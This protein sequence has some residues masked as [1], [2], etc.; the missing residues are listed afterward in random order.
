M[1][2]KKLLIEHEI[3]KPS[4]V[5]FIEVVV[6][7][8]TSEKGARDCFI[9]E[10]WTGFGKTRAV[11]IAALLATYFIKAEGQ[12]KRIIISCNTKDQQHH[13]FEELKKIY[14]ELEKILP[15]HI[16]VLGSYSSLLPFFENSSNKLEIKLCWLKGKNN[17]VLRNKLKRALERL[18]N[19]D[20]AS[21]ILSLFDTVYGDLEVAKL[22][23]QEELLKK[24]TKNIDF[25]DLLATSYTNLSSLGPKEYLW[26]LRFLLAES[27][28]LIWNHY[29][30]VLYAN[31]LYK[32][33]NLNTKEENLLTDKINFAKLS[34]QFE[35]KE[36]LPISYENFCVIFDE[37]HNLPYVYLRTNSR[38]RTL[39][40][41]IFLFKELEEIG[42][43]TT[44][45]LKEKIER[46]EK[47]VKFLRDKRNE[48]IN[49]EK[50][51]S[52]LENIGL[53]GA[54]EKEH[55]YA[56]KEAV[57]LNLECVKEIKAILLKKKYSMEHEKNFR[58]EEKRIEKINIF[59]EE[60][61]ED[62]D[63][64]EK[65]KVKVNKLLEQ[66]GQA[67][68]GDSFKE[69]FFISFSEEWKYPSLHFAC[70]VKTFANRLN[71]KSLVFTSATLSAYSG[72][73]S[74]LLKQLNNPKL[75][76]DELMSIFKELKFYP[77]ETIGIRK[78]R[79]GAI[80]IFLPEKR[81][82][83]IR[84]VCY[85]NTYRACHNQQGYHN[86]E[87]LEEE[88][89]FE[90]LKKEYLD[91][92][93]PEVK[94]ILDSE[95]RENKKIILTSKSYQEMDYFEEG[96]S[97]LGHLVNEKK[98]EHFTSLLHKLKKREKGVLLVAGRYEGYD[99]PELGVLILSRVPYT[100]Y[101]VLF[102]I[103]GIQDKRVLSYYNTLEATLNFKQLLGRLMRGKNEKTFY[104][105][106]SRVNKFQNFIKLLEKH[107]I[108]SV[109]VR[110]LGN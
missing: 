84:L 65:A 64:F 68:K 11:L 99:L 18:K 7:A 94:R 51:F 12:K 105:L 17:Y 104:V 75:R 106:D 5:E 44:K 33:G 37:A 95:L 52:E 42:I 32:Q 63:F 16:K 4:Q 49:K 87:N 39:R 27:D 66:A 78:E 91:L 102:L 40:K 57:S 15:L 48:I 60:L 73:Y 36:S 88:S 24:V 61:Q 3:V 9:L 28:I 10:A 93:L 25:E 59:W 82:K 26:Q 86:R 38:M 21:K 45:E 110:E 69:R 101:S 62:E 50:N 13:Y 100:D 83:P 1:D 54:L 35:N 2:Y 72:D 55:L 108:C 6:K 70:Q 53:V 71:F 47:L 85:L 98:R 23:D 41:G 58:T 80:K 89:F 8:L 77:L 22:L 79:I 29:L 96:L 76:Q 81:E 67:G 31:K 34:D 19:E 107:C 56:V 43:D 14:K 46:L 90:V 92:I 30:T 103:H 74:Y 97:D 109:E 20:L